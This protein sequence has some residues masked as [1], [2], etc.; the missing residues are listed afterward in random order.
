[1]EGVKAVEIPAFAAH[2]RV[3]TRREWGPGVIH[4]G[5]YFCFL[6]RRGK[7]LRGGCG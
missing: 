2:E 5:D 1:M 3:W 4:G 6:Q 7:D